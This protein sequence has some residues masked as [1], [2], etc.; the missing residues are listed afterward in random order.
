MPTQLTTSHDANG[1]YTLYPSN[2]N[3]AAY[4]WDGSLIFLVSD[5]ATISLFRVASPGSGSPSAVS[6]KSFAVAGAGASSIHNGDI[7]VVDNGNSTN[8]VWIGFAENNTVGGASVQHATFNAV[9]T[10]TWDA[11]TSV[12][13]N[14]SGSVN[15]ISVVWTG[16]YIIVG[17]RAFISGV[18]SFA[19]NYTTTKAGTGGWLA[20]LVQLSS[21][22]G[23]NTHYFG[24]LS[25]DVSLG[26][27]VAVYSMHGD[28]LTSRVLP[29]TS[30]PA[31]V[32]WGSEAGLGAGTALTQGDF[33]GVATLLDHSTGRIH[34]LYYDG[35]GTGKS[36]GY[37]TGT[38]TVNGTLSTIAWGT[39][40][41]VGT[42]STATDSPSLAIDGAGTIYAFWASGYTGASSDIK[43][44]TLASPYTSASAETN[45]TNNSTN[46]NNHPM[47]PRRAAVT[48]GYIPL[49]YVNGTGSPYGIQYDNSITA[50]S[51]LK[52]L[53]AQA[54]STFAIRT[55]LQT[56]ARSAFVVKTAVAVASRVIFYVRA[57]FATNGRGIFQVRAALAEQSRAT[58]NVRTPLAGQSRTNF[59]IRA[60]LGGQSLAT[61]NTRTSLTGQSRTTFATRTALAAQA[62]STFSVRTVL[63]TVG[64][65][66][67]K[68]AAVLS[69]TARTTFKVAAVLKTATQ[70]TFK[71]AGSAVFPAG[72][73]LSFSSAVNRLQ[74]AFAELTRLVGGWSETNRITSI[75][76]RS[77]PVA[78]PNSTIDVTAAVTLPD[79]TFPTISTIAV[80]VTF[81]DATT[82]NYSLAGGQI[83]SLGS[84][85]YKL[86]Y[87][88]KQP[89][90][91]V[92]L[93][94][95]TANDGSTGQ[96]RNV[97]GCNY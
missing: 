62:L 33:Q 10:W 40:V 74:S 41:S 50:A 60:L 6:V 18:D 3:G 93:W 37:V 57:T 4:L 77:A 70:S 17:I 36:I 87:T 47:T 48:A 32:N 2:A 75:F 78:Q 68:V 59:N 16:T 66:T 53:I 65:S 13:G 72:L 88:T 80:T 79:G 94:T 25:H 34:A 27:T 15:Q 12:I 82:S 9:G 51:G 67:F 22:S 38:I 63:S 89:G 56:Q 44:A 69:S 14:G 64:R 85:K 49:L 45:L 55:S 42:Q 5:G 73:V 23:T 19:I 28:V 7:Y 46:K 30:S 61:F 96:Y 24:S 20:S 76:V 84:G 83:V 21:L 11:A 8:D 90:N 35:S 81:P 97:T 39:P 91:H 31:L 71:I 1:G 58:F 95:F 92:E 43:Y 26:C 29:D 52:S 54:R 86:T